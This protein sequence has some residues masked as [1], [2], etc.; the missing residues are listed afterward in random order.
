MSTVT[1]ADIEQII[2]CGM[3]CGDRKLSLCDP[4]VYAGECVAEKCFGVYARRAA[5]SLKAAGL[6]K[7]PPAVVKLKSPKVRAR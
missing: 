1:A 6:L 5:A 3:C 7:Q 4:Q 2:A